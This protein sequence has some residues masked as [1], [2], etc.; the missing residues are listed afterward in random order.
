MKFLLK[1][2]VIVL[3]QSRFGESDLIIRA[4]NQ[5]GTLLSFMAKGALKSK[6]RFTGGVLEAG[7]FIG[8]EYKKSR[9][10]HATLHFLCEAWSLR[11]FESL[12]ES[13]EHL[14]VALY[15]LSLIDKTGQEGGE[16]NPNLFNLLG[17]TLSTLEKSPNLPALLFVFEFRLLLELGVLPKE[18]QKQKAL[19][20]LTVARHEELLQ[21]FPSF[22]DLA[23]I[24]HT[25]MEQ[26]MDGRHG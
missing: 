19:L 21:I 20:Q 26:Y 15:F 2:K 9:K 13:Y 3:K 12:R 7:N 23:P 5:R 22:K 14:K 18:L 1:D 10:T 17:N 11:R 8:V 6:K 25:S 16:D 4:L 24:L